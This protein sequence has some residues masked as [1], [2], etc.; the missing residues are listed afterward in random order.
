MALS[1]A[2]IITACLE[3]LSGEAVR[4]G[5]WALVGV[6]TAASVAIER[7]K[8]AARF[9]TGSPV[10]RRI[11]GLEPHH[12]PISRNVKVSRQR[13]VIEVTNSLFGSN[14]DLVR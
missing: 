14:R 1:D 3:A 6:W 13:G 10:A 12:A 5:A 4:V 8:R 2:Q 11:A 7:T 9:M